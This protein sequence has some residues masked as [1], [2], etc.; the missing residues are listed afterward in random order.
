MH[1][2]V[3]TNAKMEAMCNISIYGSPQSIEHWLPVRTRVTGKSPA[4]MTV[5][6]VDVEYIII[7]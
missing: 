2:G 3:M 6:T 5:V 4:D 7:N 1:I